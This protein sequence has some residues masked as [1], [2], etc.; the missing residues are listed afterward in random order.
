MARFLV[1]LRRD[2]RRRTAWKRSL[3]RSS[4]VSHL[5]AGARAGARSP[6][7]RPRSAA[8]RGVGR[9][10]ARSYRGAVPPTLAAGD[11]VA[12]DELAAFDGPGLEAWFGAAGTTRR[13]ASVASRSPAPVRTSSC[14]AC[15]HPREPGPLGGRRASWGTLVSSAS[16][17][18]ACDRSGRPCSTGPADPGGRCARRAVGGG[19]GRRSPE[20]PGHVGRDV[21]AGR[22]D[23]PLPTAAT[24]ARSIRGMR[25]ATWT[26]SSCSTPTSPAP[27]SS[28]SAP[29][30]AARVTRGAARR[31]GG[32]LRQGR[33]PRPRPHPAG[34]GRHGRG[35]P[36]D[37][38]GRPPGGA[39]R[40]RARLRWRCRRPR[41]GPVRR[42]LRARADGRGRAPPRR[43]GGSRR[44][45]PQRPARGSGPRSST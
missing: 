39:T 7:G 17:G 1:H 29:A 34:P 45:P 30:W 35:H 28:C 40:H 42:D 6:A 10:A 27:W 9:P 12:L 32:G 22:R 43:T 19:G 4:L 14:P 23:P 3:A 24:G 16:T 37:Q 8:G 20:P 2:R 15:S 13:R 25:P 38:R 33:A 41:P 36:P 11:V 26:R 44:H 5:G 31:A 21:L 18:S